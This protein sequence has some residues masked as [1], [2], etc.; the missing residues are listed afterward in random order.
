M[1]KEAR[2]AHRIPDEREGRELEYI[3]RMSNELARMAQD[4]DQK[5]ISYLLSM[6]S[7]A[8]RESGLAVSHANDREPPEHPVRKDA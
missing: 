7:M 8:A 5:F 3:E 1:G 4:L 2:R 6:A